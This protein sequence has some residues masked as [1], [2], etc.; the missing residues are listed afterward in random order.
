MTHSKQQQYGGDGAAEWDTLSIAGGK[1]SLSGVGKQDK[2]TVPLQL[3]YI[4]DPI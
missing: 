4:R 2:S 1:H 3:Y